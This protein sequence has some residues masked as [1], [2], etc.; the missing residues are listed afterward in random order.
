MLKLITGRKDASGM[1]KSEDVFN[2]FFT[3]FFDEF[4]TPV[5]AGEEPCNSFNVDV[6][7]DQAYYLIEADLPGFNKADL[8]I[9]YKENYLTISA[10]KTEPHV[11]RKEQFIRRERQYGL[12]SRSFFIEGIEASLIDASFTDGLLSVRIP[13][14]GFPSRRNRIPI[15]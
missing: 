12:F 14:A 4:F 11:P 9:S 13:K 7:E 8:E 6:L 10:R 2:Q 15:K 1:E 3:S 5:A